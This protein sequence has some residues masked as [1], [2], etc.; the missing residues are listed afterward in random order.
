MTL[1]YV[2]EAL[3]GEISTCVTLGQRY[4]RQRANYPWGK[5]LLLCVRVQQR[6]RRQSELQPQTCTSKNSNKKY[7]HARTRTACC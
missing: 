5:G 6:G 2:P 4:T 7:T 3:G 1:R